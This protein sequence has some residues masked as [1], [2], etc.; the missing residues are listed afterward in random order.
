M[1]AEAAL[2]AAARYGQF[3]KKRIIISSPPSELQEW[4]KPTLLEIAYTEKLRQLYR[5]EVLAYTQ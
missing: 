1:I 4:T 3:P 5:C 2:K